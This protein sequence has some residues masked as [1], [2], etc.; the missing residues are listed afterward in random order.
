MAETDLTQSEEPVEIDWVPTQTQLKKIQSEVRITNRVVTKLYKAFKEGLGVNAAC[1]YAGIYKMTYYRAIEQ[2][3]QLAMLMEDAQ[4]AQ[5]AKAV[6]V[7]KNS[8]KEGDSVTARWYLDRRDERFQ[9]KQSV[10]NQTN[11]QVNVYDGTETDGSKGSDNPVV[12]V[13]SN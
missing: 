9:A 5:L 3:P 11:I 13:K 2:S 7:V 4:E 1:R 6:K 8:L 12:D 10:G